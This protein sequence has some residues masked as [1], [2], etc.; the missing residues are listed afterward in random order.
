MTHEK[1]RAAPDFQSPGAEAHLGG[2]SEFGIFSCQRSMFGSP[3]RCSFAILDDEK[4]SQANACATKS[5][6]LCGPR[7][8]VRQDCHPRSGIGAT[9][10]PF[11]AR[12]GRLTIGRRLTTCPTLR[13]RALCYLAPPRSLRVRCTRRICYSEGT[14][15]GVV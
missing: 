8:I 2:P 6:F 7:R 10:Q 5:S 11:L 15:D 12:A 9:K 14:R 1:R 13:R 3:R 4:I